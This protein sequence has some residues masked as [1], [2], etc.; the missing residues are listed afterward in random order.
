MRRHPRDVFITLYGRKPVLE[1]IQDT[2][3]TVDK[4]LLA[5]N[6]TGRAIDEIERTAVARGI[7]CRRVT[8]R[9]VTRISKHGKQDQGVVADVIAP[10]MIPASEYFLGLDDESPVQLLAIDGVTTP[11]NVG[12]LI[13]SAVAAGISGIVLP[14]R[15]TSDI[16]P[17]LIKASAGVVFKAC[18]IRC[19]SIDEALLSSKKRGF[20]VVALTG[21]ATTNLFDASLPDRA[22][23]VVGNE[24]AGVSQRTLDLSDLRL[25]IPMSTSVESLNVACAATL[26]CFESARRVKK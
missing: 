11:A 15:E 5:R 21:N 1:A 13:R 18:L 12:L 20:S 16:N 22:V 17:L 19:E 24:S 7:R 8:P 10:D 9:E 25:S 14:R 23:Y 3:L 2:S 26:V 6:A 4:V